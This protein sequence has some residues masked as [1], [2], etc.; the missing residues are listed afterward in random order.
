MTKEKC[1][2]GVIRVEFLGRTI[3]PLGIAPQDHKIKKFLSNV[4]FPKTGKQVQC[5]IGFIN[6]YRNY[7][8]RLSEK[9][10]QFYELLKIETQLT[11]TE[12][13]LDD[14]KAI[15]TALADACGLAL[16]QPITGRQYVIMVDASFRTS[17]YALMMEKQDEKKVTSRK[18]TFAPVA[19]GSKVFSPAQLK[20]S[21][22]CK[23]FLA[24]YHAF[25]E[26]CHVLWETTLPTLVMTDNR[27]VTRFCQTKAIPPTLWN[28]CDYVLQFNFRI[29]H[30]AGTLNTAADFLSRFELTPKKIELTIREDIQ[31]LPIQINMQST[32]VAEEKQQFFLPDET[33]ETDEEILSRKQRAKERAQAEAQ[34]L[35]TAT[36]QEA[37]IIPINTTCYALGAIKEN[38]R[39]RNEQDA[40]IIL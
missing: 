10:R 2:F 27:S 1:H 8:P 12:E 36:I 25:F 39:I 40:D 29:T 31:T 37:N 5:Y 32:N 13:L 9:L 33:I 6:Y 15:N 18:K 20:M 35:I 38:A 34:A 23:E 30:V 17:G 28:A 4:R 24:I 14:Y 26:Y 19:F 11:I 16:K 3:T 21:I 7:I 22:Y